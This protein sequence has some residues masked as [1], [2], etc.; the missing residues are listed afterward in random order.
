VT[1]TL[2]PTR[3][4]LLIVPLPK[5]SIFNPP[6]AVNL[7][8]EEKI[9]GWPCFPEKIKGVKTECKPMFKLLINIIIFSLKYKY[10]SKTYLLPPQLRTSLK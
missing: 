1:D 2:P 4:H 8:K 7:V 3:P 10:L 9:Q 6:Q 5:P